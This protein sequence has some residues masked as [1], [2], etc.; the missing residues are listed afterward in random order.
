MGQSMQ[1]EYAIKEKPKILIVDDIDMNVEILDNMLSAEG[2]ETLCA[3]NVQDALGL[4]RKTKPSLILSDL[5]M[6]EIDGLEFCRMLKNNPKTRDIPFVFISVLNSGE[7][8]ERAFRAGAVDY[9]PKPFESV[10]VIMRVRNQLGSYQMQQNMAD[11]NRMMHTMVE[12]Q[13]K[14]LEQGQ[15]N[16]LRALAG[17]L[18]RRD[19]GMERHLANVG[20]NCRV[21]AQ[22]LQ[23]LPEY[24]DEITDEFIEAIETAA[25]LYDIGSL[26]VPGHSGSRDEESRERAAPYMER[27]SGEGARILQ[28]VGIEHQNGCLLTMAINIAKYRY[29]Q[30]DGTGYPA[31]QGRAIPLEA[32]ITALVRDFDR[33]S[34]GAD[35]REPLSAEAVTQVLDEGSGV[36]Y[37]PDMVEVFHKIQKQ[38]KRTEFKTSAG[39]TI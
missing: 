33:L 8:K 27:C 38:M 36:V 30:W 10:E 1:N 15:I 23:F 14:E 6:P 18:E 16:I 34:A 29:A 11:Y 39:G 28:E 32:R 37:D 7:E 20:Y 17:I 19:A 2:Y 25:K 3:L 13:K 35:G 26:V 22:A 24:G 5:S 9:I 31:I 21:F 4:I 12:E